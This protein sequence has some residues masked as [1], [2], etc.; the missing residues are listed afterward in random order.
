[1]QAY[2]FRNPT[3]KSRVDVPPPYQSNTEAIPVE[4]IDP[5]FVNVAANIVL[6][7][8]SRFW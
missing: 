4:T 6:Q 7:D 1:M 8:L 3:M 5:I 2:L